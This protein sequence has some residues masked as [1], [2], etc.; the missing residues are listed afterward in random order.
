[1]TGNEGLPEWG[2]G[3]GGTGKTVLRTSGYAVSVNVGEVESIR[4]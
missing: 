3:A 2:K 4:S 1:M